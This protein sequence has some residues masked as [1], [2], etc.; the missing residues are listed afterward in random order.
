MAVSMNGHNEEAAW[1]L[2]DK[3]KLV[4]MPE[5]HSKTGEQFD[6]K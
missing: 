6:N 1:R 3:I 4:D 5:N 2:V